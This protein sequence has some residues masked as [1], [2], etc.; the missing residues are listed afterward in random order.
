MGPGF[1]QDDGMACAVIA[2]LSSSRHCKA[3]R[4][5]AAGHVHRAKARRRESARGAI[6]LLIGLELGLAGAELLVAAPVQRLV[7]E[8]D[9]AVVGI[10]G[11]RE[12]EDLLRLA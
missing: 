11:F 12:A 9:G 2:I 7:L 3:Q 8:L 4:L 6:A 10:D 5:A 1:R